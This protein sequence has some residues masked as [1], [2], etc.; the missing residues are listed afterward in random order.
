MQIILNLNFSTHFCQYFQPSSEVLHS[1]WYQQMENLT[2]T[3]Y[4]KYTKL[5]AHIKKIFS[6]KMITE[7]LVKLLKL[8]KKIIVRPSIKDKKNQDLSGN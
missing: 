1:T 3:I 4:L 7:M 5:Q 2:H 8:L 6:E